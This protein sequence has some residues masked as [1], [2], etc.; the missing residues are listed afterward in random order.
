MSDIITI[1]N[2]LAAH[3]S[4]HALLTDPADLPAYGSDFW[5]QRGVPGVVVRAHNTEDV[6]ETLRYAATRGIPVIPRGAGTNIGVGFRPTSDS[7][8]L[9]LRQ[10]N[11]VLKIDLE[12][13]EAL[14]EPGVLNGD[15]QKLLAPAG[16]RYSPDPASAPLA[17]IGG[18][19]A[20]N[21]GGPR[22]LKYGVTFHH[23]NG[24]TCVL[25]GGE[26]LRLHALDTGPDLLGLMIGSEGTLG[27]VT[28]ARLKLSPLPQSTRTLLASFSQPEDAG[29]AVSAILATGIL[30]ATIE[31]LD[32][33]AIHLFD[34]YAPT[35]YPLDAAALI[36]DIEGSE[37]EVVHDIAV[38]ERIV[39]AA[40][41]SVRRADDEASRL[42]LWRGRLQ[43]GQALAVSGQSYSICDTTVPRS[44]IPAMQYAV[45]QIAAR[46]DLSMLMIG[47]AGDGNVHPVILF[48]GSNPRTV[49][50]VHTAASE[51]TAIALELG[52]TITGEHGIGT[53]K[54]PFMRQRFSTAEIAAM[55][56]VKQTFD[57]GGILNPGILL[58][59]PAAHEPALPHLSAT[60]Q[61]A[62]S[63]STQQTGNPAATSS[64]QASHSAERPAAH[65]VQLDADNLTV[66]TQTD[67]TLLDLRA[68]LAA[69]GYHNPI[70]EQMQAGDE[71][72]TVRDILSHP[73]YR[74]TVRDTLL[75]IKAR[76]TDGAQV[77]FGANAV[78]D[79]AGYDMKRLFIG[80]GSRFGEVEG[81]RF[82]VR[83]SQTPA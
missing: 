75:E 62:L 45:R 35:G 58:P 3:L 15:L 20:E 47:H 52:G 50:R 6:A 5:G 21:A 54:I 60:L 56:V 30:P 67:I 51:L 37:E 53:E 74:A 16:F 32:L 79:V 83:I 64:S 78:K 28:Q 61:R 80:S 48:D 81:A 1:T 12:H 11:H 43:A 27:V 4:P 14:V 25:A 76:L 9:D 71:R 41:H 2:D 68:R 57:P 39:R 65:D 40:A 17:T 46:H 34:R 73:T 18:N 33:E 36:I 7:I 38:V 10:L 26:Q 8:L 24:I 22:C 77:R 42:A 72:L 70:L 82:Q 31:Y 55:R 69:S 59:E 23:V 66:W 19:I 13:R 29:E 49:A 63:L 44:R